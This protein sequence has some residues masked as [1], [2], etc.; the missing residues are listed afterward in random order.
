MNLGEFE[1][2]LSVKSELVDSQLEAFLQ[3]AGDVEN[4][5]DGVLYALGLDIKERKRRGKRLRPV[6]C[7]LT[8]E[9]LGG[10]VE[11]ATPFALA[12]EMLHNF[13]LV[14]DDIEDHD[15]MRRGRESVW[16]RFGQDHAINIGDYM[17]AQTYHL[18]EECRSLGVDDQVVL[19][20]MKL[21]TE[22]VER[23]GEGQA[24]EMNARTRRDVSVEEYMRIVTAKTG[25]YLAAPLVGGALLAHSGEEVLNVLR[26][27][28]ER[29][30]PIFQ[31][32]DDI[33]DLTEGKG[34]GEKGSDIK[35]GK[36]SFLV[37]YTSQRCTPEERGEMYRI[38]DK[39][40]TEVTGEE[41]S[42]VISLFEKHGSVDGA[43]AKG[44]ELLGEARTLVRKLPSPLD[45]NLMA[46]IEFML[47]RKW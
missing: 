14:H 18:V 33:I 3:E 1:A 17:F 40:R 46:A 19:S 28:G 43:K 6:L 2:Y 7:L 47:G 37:V 12:C 27:L 38:L 15:E 13:L 41:V 36:R 20:L 10:D 8:C 32:T 42:W 16:V 31:M 30:G 23:T 5:H 44:R 26:A 4:L 24:L 45:A 21:I 25:F 34:R 35:E 9:S 29:I 11:R 39:P 22:T